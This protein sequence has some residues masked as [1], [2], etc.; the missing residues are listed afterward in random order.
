MAKPTKATLLDWYH[1]M[2]LIREFEETC[3]NLYWQKR[4]TGVYL[5]L[6]SGQEAVGVG[7]VAALEED[8]QCHYGLPRSWHCTGAGHRPQPADGRDDGQT[9]RSQWRQRRFDAPR[10]P[11]SQFLG[12]LCHRRRPPAAGSRDRAGI[13]LQRQGNGRVLSFVGDGATNNGYFHEAANISGVWDLPVVWVIENNLYGMG[14]RVED[15]AGQPELYKRAIAYGMKDLG[16]I[17]GQNVIEVNEAV[18]EAVKYARKNGPVLIEA[19]TYRYRGHGVSDR[20]YNERLSE[21]LDYWRFASGPDH[22]PVRV[23]DGKNYKNIEPGIATDRTRGAAGGGQGGG[24]RRD[25]PGPR[26]TMISSAIFT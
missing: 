23:S 20:Q 9:H 19:A 26:I 17:D 8:D 15:A 3:H 16:R 4:I 22:P 2:V 13:A 14:T 24:L 5:H 11:R 7:A 21:E 12:R 6:Y 25:Q 18:T 1:Q 10:Q